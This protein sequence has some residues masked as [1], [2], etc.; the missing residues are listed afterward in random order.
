MAATEIA[1]LQMIVVTA[2]RN[3]NDTHAITSPKKR[4]DKLDLSI[5][6]AF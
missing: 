3:G 2:A 4:L 6:V 5:R 1:R